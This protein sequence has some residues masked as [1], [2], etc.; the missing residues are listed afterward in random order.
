MQ[1]RNY[2]KQPAKQTAADGDNRN[3]YTISWSSHRDIPGGVR[4]QWRKVSPGRC[5]EA[6]YSEYPVLKA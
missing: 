1:E 2:N 6:L 4:G 3:V 5:T